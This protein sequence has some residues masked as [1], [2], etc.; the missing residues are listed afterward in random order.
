MENS[1]IFL[2]GG[3]SFGKWSPPYLLAWAAIGLTS[4]LVVP[5]VGLGGFYWHFG[6]SHCFAGAAI[7]FG[8]IVLALA[9]S[10]RASLANNQRQEREI[11]SRRF[12]MAEF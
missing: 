3:F 10:P 1:K 11:E 6:V 7:W 2:G 12:E 8:L 5:L 4:P 9:N